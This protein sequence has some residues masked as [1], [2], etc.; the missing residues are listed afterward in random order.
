MAKGKKTGG[1][2]LAG[3]P[4]PGRPPLPP[5]VKAMRKLTKTEFET[6]VHSLSF[7]G[8]AELKKVMANPKSTA[9][10]LMVCA[11]VMYAINR[12][13][14]G[15]I[16]F[17]LDRIIGRVPQKVEQSGPDGGP[18]KYTDLTEEEIDARLQ[19]LVKRN[20]EI[21]EPDGKEKAP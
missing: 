19:E 5:E 9:L 14:Q 1:R 11:V 18:Q 3:I 6:V 4:G 10:E 21:D 20:Q 15:R 2:S 13:D 17:I 16:D 12:G 7:M 8:R